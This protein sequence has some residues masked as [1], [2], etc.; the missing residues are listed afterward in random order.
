MFDE[1]EEMDRER[2]AEALTTP[3]EEVSPA[4]PPNTE[5]GSLVIQGAASAREA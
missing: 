1:L 3:V 4:A 2:V 5:E